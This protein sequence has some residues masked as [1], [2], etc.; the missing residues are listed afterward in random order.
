MGERPTGRTLPIQTRVRATRH[1]PRAA[2]PNSPSWQRRGKVACDLGVVRPEK[3]RTAALILP[4]S[5]PPT[6]DFARFVHFVF[7]TPYVLN[8][9][10]LVCQFLS[11][12]AIAVIM[13][14]VYC[15]KTAPEMTRSF[16][17]SPLTPLTRPLLRFRLPL[18]AV[19]CPL[20]TI[21]CAR[22]ILFFLPPLY[23]NDSV[24][25]H[26]SLVKTHFSSA[27]MCDYCVN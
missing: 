24:P 22:A 4:S 15:G 13:I 21:N 16:C 8:Q 14:C 17:P 6:S 3:L 12:N 10:I 11:K 9:Y 23:R 27:D 18:F 5:R 26:D 1:K 19:N 25:S 7:F 2:R 20:S